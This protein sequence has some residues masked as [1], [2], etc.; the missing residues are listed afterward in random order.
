M[1]RLRPP[2]GAA[3]REA[4]A[5]L[6]T[7]AVMMPVLIGFSGLVLDVG[8]WFAHKRHLQT[9]ADAGALAGAG[10]FRF[11]CSDTP[12]L[13][14][15]S[16][17]S[18]I[19]TAPDDPSYNPQIGD[20]PP[21]QLH[22]EVNSP[23][24]YG[25]AQPVDDSV[26]TGGPCA[27]RMI[28]VKLTETN[29]PW[30]LKLF[31]DV[32][33]FINTQARVEIMQQTIASGSLPVGVPEVGP[34]HARAIFVNEASGTA[35]ASATLTRTGTSAG[36]SIWT[37]AGAPA[38]VPISTA[39]IGVRILLSG[40]TASAPCGDPLVNCYGAGTNSAIV[41]GSPGLSHIRG[42]SMT[43]AGSATAPQARD[44]QLFGGG[45]EDGYFTTTAAYP[46]T[47]NV[48]AVV[49]F[50]GASISTVRV[51]AK[52]TGANNNTT[53]ELAPPAASGGAW[54]SP[55]GISIAGASGANSIDLLWQT[56][57]DADRTKNCSSTKNAL[58]SGGA[59]QRIFA[60]SES[61]SVSGPIKLLR[62]SK[63]GVPG[64]NSF[65]QGTSHDLVVTLGLKPSLDNA[66]SVDDP[67]VSLKVAGGG[68]Q[69]QALDCDPA[70]NNLRDELA[71]GC[72]PSY[73]VN[74]GSS[75]CPGGSGTL[76]ASPQPWPCVAIS[77]GATVGQVTQ[78]MNLRILG[79]ANSPSCTDPNNWAQF[80][81]FERGDP[82]IVQVFTTPFGAFT[83][84]GGTT[85]P[86]T[87]FATFYVTGWHNGG[88]QGA[89]DD[90][91]GQGEVVGHFIK[92]I[93]TLGS[94]QGE[95]QCEEATLGSCVAV[96]T[97]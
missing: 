13:E 30:W 94:G 8:N 84:S 77:T 85:V 39:K 60:G 63:D 97:R 43:P 93:D 96:F 36:L 20:T 46:C 59:A 4:G 76:W 56:G 42:F 40:S 7:V 74:D 51:L 70:E 9:Q 11:P 88:C 18:S 80:P 33:P 82:R 35:V 50:G 23:T 44:V 16:K 47:V 17:Y 55:P 89:G 58:P 27:A 45:C 32:V 22:Q 29:L 86:V 14:E 54:T 68:S 66:A 19:D 21:E 65:V 75:P 87:G 15:V 12:I 91:A 26:R 48:S 41:A 73:R 37:N 64:A 6:V 3:R 53:V 72:A 83:G 2:A 28:D 71:K 92:Y 90:P 1:R 57:C 49:D 38:S 5:V 24:W 34:R 79:E 52:R 61:L 25:Q 81:D 69:N 62:L 67:I 31:G 10:K 95:G 78:G